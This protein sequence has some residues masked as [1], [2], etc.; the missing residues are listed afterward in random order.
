MVAQFLNDFPN[1]ML[2]SFRRFKHFLT[3]LYLGMFIGLAVLPFIS[4]FKYDDT[5]FF[6]LDFTG[7]KFGLGAITVLGSM[8]LVV[9]GAF[10]LAISR[11]YF[12]MKE[13]SSLMNTNSRCWWVVAGI[14]VIYLGLDEILKI[15]EFLTWKMADLGIPKLFGIDQDVYI[16]AIYGIAAL[17]IGLKL[18]PSVSYYRQAILPLVA[19]FIFFALSEIIDFIP[20][21]SLTHNQ[22]M[23][24]GPIEEIFKTMGEWS[25]LL[26]AGLLLE[27]VITTH[28]SVISKKHNS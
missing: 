17:L 27:E 10:F 12:L 20:W 6:Y 19:T 9:T 21:F 15:H 24:L 18:L 25:F 2:A 4:L 14:G 1:T 23:F 7:E 5:L 16:F 13:P 3:P 8:F 22:Q 26:Y 11:L 28:I